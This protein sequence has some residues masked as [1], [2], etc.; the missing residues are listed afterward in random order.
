MSPYC[1]LFV[2]FSI[3]F[4]SLPVAFR[5]S[6]SP[7]LS[8]AAPLS[9]FWFFFLYASFY[10]IFSVP[11]LLSPSCP[12][13]SPLLLSPF[14]LLFVVSFLSPLICLPCYYLFCFVNNHIFVYLP[15]FLFVAASPS[16]ASRCLLSSPSVS[17]C[18]FF[19]YGFVSEEANELKRENFMTSALSALGIITFRENQP[20]DEAS[21]SG[22]R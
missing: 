18:L 12:S 15:S 1:L 3:S 14:R 2:S 16:F 8:L 17:F 20:N 10:I 13:L 21:S 7:P 11:F 4:L 9:P 19:S 5:S 6:L 22:S